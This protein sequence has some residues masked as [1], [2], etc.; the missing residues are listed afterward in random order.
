MPRTSTVHAVTA[1]GI[2]MGKNTLH[3][4]GLDSRGA[5]VLREKVSR[6]RI[7]SRLANLPP[8]L[9]GIEAGMA[10]HYVARELAALGHDVKQV[11][12]TYAKPFR[13][14]HKNDFRD[15]QAVA[16]AVQRPTTRNSLALLNHTY[17][18]EVERGRAVGF[19]AAG[20]SLALTAGPLVGGA[21]IT[22]TGWRT[23]PIGLGALW[24]TW[25][26]VT[27]TKRTKHPL[28][29]P[30]QVVAIAMLG[31]LAGAIIEG[32]RVGWQNPWIIA[33]FGVF[34]I[35][36]A[37]FL[38]QEHNT[39]QPML[40]LSLF[41]HRMF[42]LTS[43]VG[44]LVNI[45]CYGLTFVFSLY[46]Q[47]IN[48]WSPLSTGLAFVPMTGIVLPV[49]LIAP[50][51]AERFGAPAVIAVGCLI[52]T[53]GCVALLGI[54]P[55]TSYWAICAQLVAMGGGLGL[56]VP[57]LTSA[58]LG[59]D[60]KSRSGVAAGVFNSTRQAGS[61][62]GVALFGSLIERTNAFMSGVHAALIISA[63]LLIVAG[64]A[65]LSALFRPQKP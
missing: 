12:P 9:I 15:A 3:M 25:R 22:L 46:F 29:L 6:G 16:E 60:E 30:G 20:A 50:R 56:L 36:A 35:L 43:L 37:L 42:A 28:D 1:I 32:G 14:G 55:G 51:L 48:G 38:M 54:K 31:V 61:V 59:S 41:A 47:Q 8:C 64:G 52:A 63:A 11:P 18:G 34:I 45:A 2:D 49:N 53:S 23:I 7:T 40:P 44:L 65:I 4:V 39:Q 62:I 19:W 57:P 24:L 10:T 17:P 33:S 5:I 26:Y 13:Q 58:L 27:D 21:L